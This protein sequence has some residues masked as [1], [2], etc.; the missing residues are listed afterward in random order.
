MSPNFRID[1][2]LG[3]TT[4]ADPIIICEEKQ[5]DRPEPAGVGRADAH[6]C[7]AKLA[8]RAMVRICC[9]RK[10]GVTNYE[11]P[12]GSTSW[13]RFPTVAPPRSVL[14]RHYRYGDAGS[15]RLERGAA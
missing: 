11:G 14:R 13:P 6:G 5:K 3:E 9:C 2:C 1:H 8:G 7:A 12:S 15:L 4:S 10:V